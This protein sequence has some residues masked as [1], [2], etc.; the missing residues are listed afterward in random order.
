MMAETALETLLV[1]YRYPDLRAAQRVVRELPMAI[2]LRK[3]R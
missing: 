3:T 1:E 2:R